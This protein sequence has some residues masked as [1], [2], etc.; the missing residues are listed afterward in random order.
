MVFGMSKTEHS[1][2]STRVL[3]GGIQASDLHLLKQVDKT[4]VLLQN[5]HDFSLKV[6]QIATF[7]CDQRACVDSFTVLGIE[8]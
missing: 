2:T 6:K 8:T 5:R 3:S 7:C 1:N 4:D